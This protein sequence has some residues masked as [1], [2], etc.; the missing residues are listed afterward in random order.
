MPYQ[1][2]EHPDQ[3]EV[4]IDAPREAQEA[5]LDLLEACTKVDGG[6]PALRCGTVETFIPTA[7]EGPIRIRVVPFPG[8]RIDTRVIERCLDFTLGCSTRRG[9]KACGCA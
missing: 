7:G 1:I 8:V 3:L 9:A 4:A 2:H 6:C 5:F